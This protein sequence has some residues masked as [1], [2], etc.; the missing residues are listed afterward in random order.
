M[1]SQYKKSY[2]NLKELKSEIEHLQHLLEQGRTRMTRD[3]EAW[4]VEVYQEVEEQ[5]HSTSEDPMISSKLSESP[6]PNFTIGTHVPRPTEDAWSSRHSSQSTLYGD[7]SLPSQ[8]LRDIEGTKSRLRHNEL[9]R[10]SPSPL[11]RTPSRQSNRSVTFE[12][13]KRPSSSLGRS[14]NRNVQEDIKAFYQARQEIMQ[15]VSK[16]SQ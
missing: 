11:E 6:R 10:G 14:T 5:P 3:F 1:V 9:H 2:Q 15:R 7:S 4:Y 8:N 12:D 16:S 13:T